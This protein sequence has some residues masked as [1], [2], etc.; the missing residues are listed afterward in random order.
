M[1]PIDFIDWCPDPCSAHG[2]YVSTCNKRWGNAFS[3]Y[4]TCMDG[5]M[6]RQSV[7]SLKSGHI[8]RTGNPSAHV[9][10]LHMQSL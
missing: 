2:I 6:T 8:P 10:V 4:E 3:K 7:P 9:N 5:I 1:A